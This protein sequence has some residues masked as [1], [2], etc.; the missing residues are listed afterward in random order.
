MP[1]IIDFGIAKATT[2]PLTDQPLFTGIG[3]FVGT[4]D[5][6]SPEQAAMS[7]VD[8]DTRSD[9]YSLGVLLYE[10]LTGTMP[11]DSATLREAGV[12]EFRRVIR[13]QEPAKPSTRVA[14]T[15]ADTTTSTASCRRTVPARLISS[16]RGDLDWITI[17]A[18]DK[19]RTRRYQTVNALALDIRRHLNHEPVI[20]GPPSAVYRTRKFVR[21]HRVAVAAAASVIVLL[22]GVA[23]LTA[24]QRSEERR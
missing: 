17:K 21:R 9:V 20:A 1:H 11:F 14:G 13:E 12:D 19:D 7:S 8:V 10:L 16:L 4:L 5:Y 3:G 18:L 2:Q 22:I 24:V 6:M 23:A 15:K